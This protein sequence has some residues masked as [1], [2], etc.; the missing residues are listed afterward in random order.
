MTKSRQV[1]KHGKQASKATRV[2]RMEDRIDKR[3]TYTAFPAPDNS[4]LQS[5]PIISTD[6]ILD[7]G[8][9]YT[10]EE[11]QVINNHD[12]LPI[13]PARRAFQDT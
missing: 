3:N 10:E 11:M 9:P 6:G 5:L 1:R 7:G 12:T 2:K 13:S 4:G 8:E